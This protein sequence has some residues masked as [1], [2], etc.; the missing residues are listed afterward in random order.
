ML[1]ST[2]LTL[3]SVIV[4]VINDLS[5]DQRVDRVCRTLTEMGFS[6]KLTGRKKRDSIP[7]EDKPYSRYRMWLIFEKGPFFYAEYNLRLFIYLLFHK[8]DLLVSNDLDTLL[9]NY[10]ISKLKACPLFY[11]S[12][13]NFTEVPELKGR[14]FARG[15]WKSIER[16][17]F[18]RLKHVFT[19][20]ESLAGIFREQYGVDVNVV[21]NTP[22]YREYRLGK[23]RQELGLPVDRKIF[24]M[25]GA[26]INID[27][28][29]EE[30][31]MAMQFIDDGMLLIIGGGDVINDLKML[32]SRLNLDE[33]VRFLPKMP[34]DELYQYSVH[35]D[36]GLS[37]DKDSNINYRYSLPNKLFDYIQA[38]IPVLTSPL[39]EVS[40]IVSQY[41]IGLLTDNHYPQH[42]AEKLRE[43][44]SDLP[45]IAKW[46]ENLNF[47][48]KDLCWE[49]EKESLISVYKPY[50]G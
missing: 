21:R 18:P 36:A 44:T 16:A 33:K 27:R 23:S 4:S 40:R 10:L 12:H 48:A 38:R 11:D 45:R 28:G 50:A 35:A 9:P 43:M 2:F 22:Y 20:N 49:N 31:I 34:F 13:E 41:D 19:V 42:I 47:A 37:L 25:Q 5:T 39:P 17:L 26:G 3:K 15:I 30:A 7:L 29:A 1:F 32:S 24:L 6:V 14:N 8:T 46:K